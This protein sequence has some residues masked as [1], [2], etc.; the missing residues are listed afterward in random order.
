MTEQNA[1]SQVSDEAGFETLE[2][3]ADTDKFNQWLF[4]TLTKYCK[5][6]ILE[7]GSGIGNIS[8]LLLQKFVTVSLSDLRVEYCSMLHQKFNGNAHLKSIQK[9]DLSEIAFENKYASLQNN[10]DSIIAS[11]VIE[12]IKD[13]HLAIRNCRG[14]LRKN[15]RLA[16]LVPA[17]STLYNGFDKELGHFRRYNKRNLSDL[18]WDEGFEIIH[19]QYFNFAGIFG[20]WL[21]GSLLK[22]KIL[23]KNQ[24]VIYN[25]LVPVIKLADK[26]LLNRFGLSVIVVGEKK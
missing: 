23:P 12:H 2:I 10:F 25:K 7:I 8:A 18:F 5:D 24:L 1:V 13:D 16:V 26:I 11:N 21:S 14:M 15:G 17:Y 6:N 4:D 9:I 22:K 19:S 3:F 20:W